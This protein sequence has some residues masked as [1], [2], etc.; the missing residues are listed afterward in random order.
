MPRNSPQVVEIKMVASSRVSVVRT[1]NLVKTSG[2]FP[3]VF[4]KT[5]QTTV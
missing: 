5:S 1:P 4:R 2:N 3:G